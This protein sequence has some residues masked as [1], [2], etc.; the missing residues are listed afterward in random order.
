M[1]RLFWLLRNPFRTCIFQAMPKIYCINVA[2]N[3][4]DAQ[5]EWSLVWSHYLQVHSLGNKINHKNIAV[6]SKGCIECADWSEFSPFVRAIVSFFSWY[7]YS[8][9]PDQ[10]Y[11]TIRPM[12]QIS[13]DPKLSMRTGTILL[14]IQ[15]FSIWTYKTKLNGALCLYLSR[16]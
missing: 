8:P 12:W 14:K 3:C 9:T 16:T 11:M 10:P 15:R 2:H 4:E 7:M 5:T 1:R 13:H 6:W